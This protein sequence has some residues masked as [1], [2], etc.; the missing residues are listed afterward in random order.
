MMTVLKTWLLRFSAPVARIRVPAHIALA[1]LLVAVVADGL[2]IE[3]SVEHLLLGHTTLIFFLLLGVLLV[4]AAAFACRCLD[5]KCT[6][7]CP[8]AG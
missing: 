7:S 5:C 2:F 8:E 3:R 6:T 1:L 4:E